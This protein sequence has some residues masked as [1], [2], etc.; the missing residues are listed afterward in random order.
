[1]HCIRVHLLLFLIFLTKFVDSEIEC[2][3]GKCDKWRIT[4]I[5]LLKAEN[6]IEMQELQSIFHSIVDDCK[7]YYGYLEMKFL[8]K[9]LS[10]MTI[11]DPIS[12]ALLD[13]QI[14]DF[15]YTQQERVNKSAYLK[16]V[17]TAV[18]YMWPSDNEI[19]AYI[20]AITNFDSLENGSGPET[21]REIDD[22][23]EYKGIHLR[24]VRLEL[25]TNNKTMHW[26]PKHFFHNINEV[27]DNIVRVSVVET[28]NLLE[29]IKPCPPL[30][31]VEK[32]AQLSYAKHY[33]FQDRRSSIIGGVLLAIAIISAI[34]S[35]LFSFYEKQRKMRKQEAKTLQK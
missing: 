19:G 13:D 5:P 33:K 26:N 32:F 31:L 20:L 34:S 12:F 7:W 8:R 2:Q 18:N 25:D 23:L 3:L 17:T 14:A 10:F 4:V 29:A 21:M 27:T 15:S 9:D 30:S 22:R 11:T 35:F 16:A 6:P 28:D 24:I 1:M